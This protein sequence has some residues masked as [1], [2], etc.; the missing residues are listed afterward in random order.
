MAVLAAHARPS[1]KWEIV[2]V[3][4]LSYFFFHKFDTSIGIQ[5]TKCDEVFTQVNLLA[6]NH[7]TKDYSRDH[8]FGASYSLGG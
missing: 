4:I 7:S 5:K 6:S 1:P 8:H 3:F 2:K